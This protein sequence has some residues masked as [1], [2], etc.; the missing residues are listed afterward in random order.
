MRRTHIPA[1]SILIGPLIMGSAA[2]GDREWQNAAGGA[3]YLNSNWNP[4]SYPSLTDT[5]IFGMELTNPVVMGVLA[6]TNERLILRDADLTIDLNG[7]DYTLTATGLP[8]SI[9][10]GETAPDIGILDIINGR[11]IGENIRL[12][13][14]AGT[15]GNLFVDGAVMTANGIMEI[16]YLGSSTV[17]LANG[18]S[19]SGGYTSLATQTGADALVNVLSG[20]SFN[21][22]DMDIGAAGTASFSVLGGSTAQCNDANIGRFT[23]PSA[24]VLIRDA[25]STWTVN[26]QLSVGTTS[27]GD[28]TIGSDAIVTASSGVVGET[29][30][31]DG[32]ITVENGNA[33]LD[34]TNDFIVAETGPGSM[35]IQTGGDVTIGGALTIGASL[36]PVGT[37]DVLDAGSSLTVE[38]ALT[39]G[40]AG[41]GTLTA[42]FGGLVTAKDVV[43]LGATAGSGGT[44]NIF[45]DGTV[46]DAADNVTVGQSHAGILSI[47]S[48]QAD[49][50]GTCIIARLPG[51]S[52]SA[53]VQT[54]GQ[55]FC[56]GGISVAPGGILGSLSCLGGSVVRAPFI[57]VEANGVLTGDSA[58]EVTTAVTNHGTVRAGTALT[59]GVLP[60]SGDFVQSAGGFTDL[61][62]GGLVKGTSH[63]AVDV[64]GTATLAGQLAFSLDTGF[65][66]GAGDS[67]ELLT[68]GSIVGTMDLVT[69]PPLPLDSAWRVNYDTASTPNSISA[70]VLSGP[71][72]YRL[73]QW[74]AALGDYV[75]DGFL[76]PYQTSLSIEDWYSRGTP[77]SAQANFPP[78]EAPIAVNDETQVFLIHSEVDGLCVTVHHD[79]SVNPLGGVGGGRAEMRWDIGGDPNGGQWLI[80]DDPSN[81]HT[82]V[83]GDTT[84]DMASQWGDF[85]DGG[86]LGPLDGAQWEVRARF[87]DVHGAAGNEMN[88]LT[89]WT[90]YSDSGAAF[91]LKLELDR[92]IRIEIVPICAQAD[93]NAD[94]TVDVQDLIAM[95]TAWGPN[96]GHPADLN[97]DGA[98]NVLDLLIMLSEWGAC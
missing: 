48:G 76:A 55:L 3:F 2:A 49:I 21:C 54:A 50:D 42:N 41:A 20:S 64:T 45:D 22:A 5:A 72:S 17:R 65:L 83:F 79:R 51:S 73:S 33:L 82:G 61:K 94:G 75:V 62:I 69:F 58:F 70:E 8:A 35:T 85:A 93:L 28:L 4:A 19:Y 12:A 36:G 67:F 24:D 90:A 81:Y 38:G 7:N 16:G 6:T 80:A 66:P 91:A 71:Y 84:F 9:V 57:N 1:L 13:A 31:G 46:L 56:D 23:A 47:V 95:L 11:L 63:D 87:T 60:I 86:V 34:V 88:G 77:Y 40:E 10:I 27:V 97:G 89:D 96:P 52:G 53:S 44:L 74:D 25:G 59:Y 18:A 37:V 43:V 98:V 26:G 78:G 14:D 29:S 15:Q 30:T 39:I 68:A 92:P 32:S